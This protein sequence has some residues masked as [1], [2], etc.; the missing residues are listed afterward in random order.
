M[1]SRSSYLYLPSARVLGVFHKA[2]FTMLGI[3]PSAL[4]MSAKQSTLATESHPRPAVSLSTQ[5]RFRNWRKQNESELR[6]HLWVLTGAAKA[7]PARQRR[8][9]IQALM[10]LGTLLRGENMGS[11]RDTSS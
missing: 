3:K 2:G 9:K 4:C 5:S 1:N 7:L 8:K 11:A 6:H 10:M